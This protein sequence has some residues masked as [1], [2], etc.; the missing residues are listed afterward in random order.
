MKFSEI[1]GHED[2]KKVLVSMAD[3]GRVPHAMLFYENEGCGGLAL[4]LAFIQYI[5]CRHRHDGDSCGECPSCNKISKL[6]HPD[7]HFVFPV[8]SGPKADSSSKPTSDSYIR[9]WRELVL[10]NPY[11]LE[12]GLY[13]AL[14]IE[15]NG[16]ISN[17]AEKPKESGSWINAGFFVCEPEVFDYIPEDCENMM[18]EEDP[19]KNLTKAGQMNAYKHTGFWHAMDMLKDKEDL[20]K[21]WAAGEAPWKLWE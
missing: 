17:F 12:N 1:I 8:T 21:M 14:G 6:I 5:N 19:L 16:T 10:G 9:Y 3:S 4:A 7:M 13:K 11:F 18:W 20:N 2:I 15:G